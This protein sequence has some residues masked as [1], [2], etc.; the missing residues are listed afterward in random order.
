MLKISQKKLN[1]MASLKKK[2]IEIELPI[3]NQRIEALSQNLE[4]RTIKVDLTRAL[5]GKSVEA[6]FTLKK[7]VAKLRRVALLGFYI[8]RLLRKNISYVEESFVCETKDA[9]LRIKPFLITRKKV[10]RSIR[11]SLRLETIKLIKEFCKEK[12]SE[13]IFKAVIYSSLQKEL[14]VKLK[15]IYPLSLCEI[16]IVELEKEKSRVKSN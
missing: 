3:I 8:R 7:G 6:T 13:E 16:R 15:K 4:D 11:N 14:S 2:T 10:Y 5:R 12:T 1:K 9:K